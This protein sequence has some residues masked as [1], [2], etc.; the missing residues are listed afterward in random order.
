[1]CSAPVAP[2]ML[3]SSIMLSSAICVKYLNLY[4]VGGLSFQMRASFTTSVA[5]VCIVVYGISSN[6][7]RIIGILFSLLF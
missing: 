2:K 3:V 4:V 7:Q 1:M 5:Y 6:G